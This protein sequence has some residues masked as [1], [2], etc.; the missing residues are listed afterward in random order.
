MKEADW[1]RQIAIREAEAKRESAKALADAEIIRAKGVAEAN[2][3]IE[4]EHINKIDKSWKTVQNGI[5]IVFIAF[6]SV[7]FTLSVVGS[8]SISVVDMNTIKYSSMSLGIIS[9]LLSYSVYHRVSK[10]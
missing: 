10:L 8:S 4:I 7:L 3:I 5:S 9:L 1:N 6:Y 2:E